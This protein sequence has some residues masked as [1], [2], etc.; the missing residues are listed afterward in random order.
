MTTAS[1]LV[2]GDSMSKRMH[3]TTMV[4]PT[5]AGTAYRSR[6]QRSSEGTSLAS[7]S[8]S[9]PP[10]TAVAS[11]RVADWVR[12]RPY[13]YAFVV[14][15]TQN[16]PRP[17]ASKTFTPTWM[18][19][20]CGCRKKTRRAASSGV[21]KYPRSVKAAG[22]TA[23][24]IRSRNSPPPSAVTSART[25]MPKTSKFLRTASRAPEIAKTKMPIRSSVCWTEGLNSC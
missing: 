16:R 18:R 4:A 1:A 11:P 9:T 13:S 20:T 7:T 21:R 19:S 15:A 5:M 3:R 22:G 23:P 25:A 12:P 14:P 10:P 24:M 8:R 6:S 2:T 17:A